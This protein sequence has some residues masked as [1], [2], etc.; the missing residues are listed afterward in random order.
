M[1]GVYCIWKKE[2]KEQASSPLTYILV[3]LFGGLIGWLFFNYLIAAKEPSESMLMNQVMTPTFGN[4]N[5]IFLFLAPLL[6]MKSFAE[7]RKSGTLDLLLMSPFSNLSII[8]AKLCSTLTIAMVMLGLTLVFPAI[9]IMSGLSEWGGLISSYLGLIFSITCYLSVGI[10]ASSLTDNMIISA[11]LSF[12]ILL[13]L[14]LLVFT[15]NVTDNYLLGLI[16]QYA[17]TPFHFESM[18]SGSLKSYSFV[19]F[20]SFIGF[21]LY[22]TKVSLEARKW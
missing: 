1:R 11:L 14:M 5:F 7:E 3:G 21:F 2:I 17:S 4:M 20:V 22:L 16:F 6:T 9:L 13:G 19:Y 15:A 8:L 10:F 12:C 18:L